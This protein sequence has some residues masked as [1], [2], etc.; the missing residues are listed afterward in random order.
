[1]PD[2]LTPE[3]ATQD[4]LI[5]LK[6][7]GFGKEHKRPVKV[8]SWAERWQVSGQYLIRTEV[9]VR[10]RDWWNVMHALLLLPGGVC[11]T[12]R[13]VIPVAIWRDAESIRP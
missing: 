10:R 11:C 5:A 6:E 7:A 2:K 12:N 9:T 4:A 13:E 1:V 3:Q 8:A